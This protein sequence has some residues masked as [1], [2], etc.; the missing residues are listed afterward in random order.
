MW[1]FGY[2]PLYIDRNFAQ[3]SV[4][5]KVLPCG[6]SWQTKLS[7]KMCDKKTWPYC[8]LILLKK[9]DVKSVTLWF[10][11]DNYDQA[12][13]K[14]ALKG[15]LLKIM[16]PKKIDRFVCGSQVW[17]SSLSTSHFFEQTLYYQYLYNCEGCQRDLKDHTFCVALFWAKFLLIIVV[18][19]WSVNWTQ[20]VTFYV[21]LF[22]QN[23]Y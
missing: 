8:T 3:K 21:I 13:V 19:V 9:W 17:S 16:R 5:Y 23:F 11:V 2:H 4:T 1:P 22:E 10:E 7:H 18:K 20:R 15:I 12:K 6:S 14:Y